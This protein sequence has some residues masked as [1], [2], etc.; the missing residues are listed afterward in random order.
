MIDFGLSVP[1]T[2]E[3]MQPG[4]RT[5]TPNYMAPEVVRRR[6]TDQR[7]D[8]FA[9]GVSMYE[10][11]SFDL[12]WQRGSDGLAAMAHGQSEPPPL[13]SLYPSVHPDLEAAIHKCMKAD[14]NDRFPTMAAFLQA[15][16]NIRHEDVESPHPG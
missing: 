7:L 10:M 9:F 15:I 11:F 1:A 6:P 5:G 13:R 2:K 12:P 16:R 4:N 8:M 14:P 3:F